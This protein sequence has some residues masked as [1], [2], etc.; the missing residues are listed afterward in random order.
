MADYEKEKDKKVDDSRFKSLVHDSHVLTWFIRSNV[1]E[2]KNSSIEE[3]RSC[4]DIGSNGR[5][6]IGR[7][8]EIISPN[9]RK[10][11]PDTIFELRLPGSDDRV[12]LLINIE[13]QNNPNPGYPLE[14]RV[15]FYASGFVFSQRGIY[16]KNKDYGNLRKVYSIWYILNLR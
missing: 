10:A 8:T 5:T 12:A 4:L 7:E 1:D 13:G 2:F 3:I 16:F 14:K 6:V 9:S 11:I 15:E